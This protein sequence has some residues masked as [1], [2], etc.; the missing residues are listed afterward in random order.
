MLPWDIPSADPAPGASKQGEPTAH[1]TLN[2]LYLQQ[3]LITAEV[4]RTEGDK[5]IFQK[6]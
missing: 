3:F 1:P 4:S 6:L 5:T 2:S